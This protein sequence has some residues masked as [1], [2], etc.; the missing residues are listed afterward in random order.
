MTPPLPEQYSP[1][2]AIQGQVLV[3]LGRNQLASRVLIYDLRRLALALNRLFSQ[4]PPTIRKRPFV[5]FRATTVSSHGVGGH[6]VQLHAVPRELHL[7]IS[8][9]APGVR[10]L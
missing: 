10:Y 3:T 9:S 1:F 7:G 2:P 5:E 4:L 8:R 6:R